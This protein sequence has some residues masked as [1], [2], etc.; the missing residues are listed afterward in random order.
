[1][2]A[3]IQIDGTAEVRIKKATEAILAVVKCHAN[4]SVVQQA[5]IT[6]C[7]LAKNQP[8]TVSNCTLTNKP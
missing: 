1:M 4:E 8:V 6:L 3:M 7:E 5:L 2:K